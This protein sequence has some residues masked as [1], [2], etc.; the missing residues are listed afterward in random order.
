MSDEEQARAR[1]FQDQDQ[2]QSLSQGQGQNQGQ[3]QQAQ[4]TNLHNQDGL[5]NSQNAERGQGSE[6]V[7]EEAEEAEEAEI[8]FNSLPL[9]DQL[10]VQTIYEPLVGHEGK[11]YCPAGRDAPVVEFTEEYL[12]MHPPQVPLYEFGPEEDIV[13]MVDERGILLDELGEP[14]K[15]KAARFKGYP[16][17][18]F[19]EQKEGTLKHY[20]VV[21]SA[22]EML[23][24]ILDKDGER[25]TTDQIYKLRNKSIDGELSMYP[26]LVCDV[27]AEDDFNPSQ[28]YEPEPFSDQEM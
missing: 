5:S 1:Q 14:K 24:F 19:G 13:I 18:Y 2:S 8:D 22:Q 6:E 12:I 23:H 25:M 3:G 7:V 26:G 16:I 21:L 17:Y 10:E 4:Q 27:D 20:A 11:I 15:I 9:V 28:G